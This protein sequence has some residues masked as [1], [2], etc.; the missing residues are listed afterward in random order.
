MSIK[1]RWVPYR[2]KVK[3]H[4]TDG[5]SKAVATKVEV[6]DGA[7]ITVQCFAPGPSPYARNF[8]TG[9]TT[10]TTRGKYK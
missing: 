6:I 4:S 7:S 5:W 10:R 1:Q 9:K 8:K 3:I 2:K